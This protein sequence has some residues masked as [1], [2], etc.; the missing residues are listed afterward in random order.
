[1]LANQVHGLFHVCDVI[2]ICRLHHSREFSYLA[3]G[4]VYLSGFTLTNA[5]TL[6]VDG[7]NTIDISNLKSTTPVVSDALV[8][9]G[10]SA[11][12]IRIYLIFRYHYH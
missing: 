3:N 4:N 11:C 9:E 5:G 6:Y 2:Y 8:I 10:Y 1:M 12:I 7:N